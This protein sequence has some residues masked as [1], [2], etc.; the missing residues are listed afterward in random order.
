MKKIIALSI[1]ALFTVSAHSGDSEKMVQQHMYGAQS[2]VE[3]S[4]PTPTP[5]PAPKSSIK[6][7]KKTT[8]YSDIKMHKKNTIK[9]GK[10]GG[11]ISK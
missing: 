11:S 8:P 3:S 9:M 6:M 1:S 7:H 10:P 5:T 2:K 4:K